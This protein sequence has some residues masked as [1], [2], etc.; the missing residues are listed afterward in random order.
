MLRTSFFIHGSVSLL[1]AHLPLGAAVDAI[2]REI[3][4]QAA[5]EQKQTAGEQKRLREINI[6][7][8][9]CKQ[10]I[11]AV[12]AVYKEEQT[13]PHKHVESYSPDLGNHLV[14][15]TMF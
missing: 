6:N 8:T 5:G 11:K 2:A 7:V 1:R 9:V 10:S 13:S 14:S 3:A 12:T 4:G 15:R